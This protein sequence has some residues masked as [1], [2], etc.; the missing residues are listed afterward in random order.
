MNEDLEMTWK[1][2][3]VF[4]KENPDYEIVGVEQNMPIRMFH[5]IK[6][7]KENNIHKRIIEANSQEEAFQILKEVPGLADFLAYQVFVDLTYIPEYKFSENEFT[8][9]GPGC[10]RGLDLL[11]EDKDGMNSEEALFWVRDNIEAEWDK[12]GLHVD[13]EEL[14]DHLSPEDRHLNVMMLENSMCELGKISKAKRGT[15]R[16]RNRYVPTQ[17]SKKEI[18]D[19]LNEWF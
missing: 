4:V 17:D 6:W 7:A 13:F 2:A 18:K 12:R 16:P 1:E 8:I 3:K 10:D 15:G 9:S 11:F 19:E 5:L 14:F